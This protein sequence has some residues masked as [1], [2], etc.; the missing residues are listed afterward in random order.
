VALLVVF[1]ILAAATVAL[2]V[3]AFVAGILLSLR[4][5]PPPVPSAPSSPDDEVRQDGGTS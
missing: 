2:C 1:A 5:S 4:S 3:F